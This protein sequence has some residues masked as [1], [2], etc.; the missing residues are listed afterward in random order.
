MEIQLEFDFVKEF[1]YDCLC[2]EVAGML[3]YTRHGVPI[4]D[5]QICH[6]TGF[7]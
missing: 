1:Q 5:C 3:N 4:E 7:K 6:G 2:L